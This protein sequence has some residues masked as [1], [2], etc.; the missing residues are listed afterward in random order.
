MT[1][2]L[3]HIALAALAG[4]MFVIG[5]LLATRAPK[6]TAT[7]SSPSSRPAARRVRVCGKT[8]NRQFV[9]PAY[10]ALSLLPLNRV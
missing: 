9:A 10:D 7:P 2:Q 8:D 6:S 4:A 1:R 3:Q 5:L